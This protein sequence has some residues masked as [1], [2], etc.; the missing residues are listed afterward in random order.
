MEFASLSSLP[1]GNADFPVEIDGLQLTSTVPPDNESG[2]PSYRIIMTSY[3]RSIVLKG[4]IGIFT[5][6]HNIYYHEYLSE[7]N[8]SRGAMVLGSRVTGRISYLQIMI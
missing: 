6:L 1:R 5:T 8:L 2:A 4:K 7:L 3:R